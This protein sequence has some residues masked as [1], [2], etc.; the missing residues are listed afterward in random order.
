MSSM[1]ELQIGAGS[2]A[3]HGPAPTN[4]KLGLSFRRASPEVR[5]K[6]VE[7]R[8]GP[9]DWEPIQ[10]MVREQDLCNGTIGT[11]VGSAPG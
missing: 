4:E 5:E 8:R 2:E 1:D 11:D 6:M 7:Q 10:R 3:Y 9:Q